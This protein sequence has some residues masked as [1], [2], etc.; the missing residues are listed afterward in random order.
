MSKIFDM[1]NRTEGVGSSNPGKTPD[2]NISSS[3][4]VSEDNSITGAYKDNDQDI[5]AYCINEGVQSRL[6]FS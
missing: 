5:L 6:V 4:S 1:H 2:Q 3:F